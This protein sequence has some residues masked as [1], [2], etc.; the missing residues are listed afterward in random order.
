MKKNKV[1]I[2]LN[3]APISIRNFKNKGVAYHEACKAA[4]RILKQFSPKQIEGAASL[5]NYFI[6]RYEDAKQDKTTFRQAFSG[7]KMCEFD[8]P[9]SVDVICK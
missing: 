8:C 4:K 7:Y 5:F 3:G 6:N 2:S 1:I 9:V